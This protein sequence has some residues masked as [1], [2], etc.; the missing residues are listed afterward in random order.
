MLITRPEPGA[1]ESR[2][3]VSALGLRPVL[4]PALVYRRLARLGVDDLDGAQGAVFTSAASVRAAAEDLGE[5]PEDVTAYCVGEKTAEAARRAGFAKVVVGSGDAAGVLA[6]LSRIDPR[7]GALV[8]LRGRDVAAP[9]AEPLAAAGFAVREHALYA[10]DRADALSAEAAR[11]LAGG[12][13]AFAL[14]LSA[15]T[16]RA[17]LELAAIAGLT[18]KLSAVAALCNS[19]RTAAPLRESG[20]FTEIRVAVEPTLVATLNLS[21]SD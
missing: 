14:F 2:A 6:E 12:R 1:S 8:V 7:R 17:F 3:A 9:L 21:Q 16:A 18:E 19:E 15:R 13:A 10:A 20:D 11:A 5:P 4:A